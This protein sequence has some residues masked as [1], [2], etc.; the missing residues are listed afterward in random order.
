MS[1]EVPRGTHSL[2]SPWIQAGRLAFF[3]LYAVTLLAALA[4]ASGASAYVV[5]IDQGSEA[6]YLRASLEALLPEV[7]RRTLG[8]RADLDRA[9]AEA[10]RQPPEQ[11]P[12]SPAA[13][14]IM[15]RQGG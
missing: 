6:V 8:L 2:N 4:W 1:D 3:A 9:R 10:E 5:P 14:E 15:R 7:K 13:G 11:Q 12:V